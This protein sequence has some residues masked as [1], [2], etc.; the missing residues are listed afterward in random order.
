[1]TANEAE[2]LSSLHLFTNRNEASTPITPKSKIARKFYDSQNSCECKRCIFNAFLKGLAFSKFSLIVLGRLFQILGP[3][4]F[5]D[6]SVSFNL[7]L[8][9]KIFEFATLRVKKE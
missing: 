2:G 6:L 4:I 1:M 5:I 7:F 8:I 9:R 3:A